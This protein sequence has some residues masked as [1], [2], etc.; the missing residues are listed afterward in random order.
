MLPARLLPWPSPGGKGITCSFALFMA[1]FIGALLQIRGESSALITATAKP[2]K[3]TEEA[4]FLLILT[5]PIS[6]DDLQRKL[7]FFS[8]FFSSK[9]KNGEVGALES[10]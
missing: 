2:Q 10:P 1:V 9:L 3:G 4:A 6:S 7:F 5:Q 8:F